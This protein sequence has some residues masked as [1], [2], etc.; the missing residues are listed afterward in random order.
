MLNRYLAICEDDRRRY[1]M[2]LDWHV[3]VDETWQKNHKVRER[4]DVASFLLRYVTFLCP[5]AKIFCS[6]VTSEEDPG[7]IDVTDVCITNEVASHS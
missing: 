6:L 5:K 7:L 2:E 1:R 4:F 3:H